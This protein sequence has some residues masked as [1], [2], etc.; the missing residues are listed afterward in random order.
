MNTKLHGSKRPAEHVVKDIRRATRRHFS[1]ED[2]IRIDLERHAKT[3]LGCSK[4]THTITGISLHQ[5]PRI[6]QPSAGMLH[7]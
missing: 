4:R 2:K 5:R 7:P 6:Q 3:R 1:S